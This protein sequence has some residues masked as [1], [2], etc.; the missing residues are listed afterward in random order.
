[1]VLKTT[2]QQNEPAPREFARPD[3]VPVRSVDSVDIR[4]WLDR[5]GSAFGELTTGIVRLRLVG[6]RST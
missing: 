6:N 2:I 4:E 5:Q 3:I 1:L